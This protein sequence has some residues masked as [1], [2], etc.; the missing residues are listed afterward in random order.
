ML[1]WKWRCLGLP[2]SSH[3]DLWDQLVKGWEV[4]FPSWLAQTSLGTRSHFPNQGL[5]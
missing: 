3:Q 2:Y 5:G 1:P 4:A